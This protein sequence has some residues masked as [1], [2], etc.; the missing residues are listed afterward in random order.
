MQLQLDIMAKEQTIDAMTECTP[1]GVA[2]AGDGCA[3]DE[4]LGHN[5]AC[6]SLVAML[7]VRQFRQAT[8]QT[9]ASHMP[10]SV[11][12]RCHTH[13]CSELCTLANEWSE[14]PGKGCALARL[15]WSISGRAC[16]CKLQQFNRACA[17]APQMRHINKMVR[18]VQASM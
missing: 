7:C 14:E 8:E 1:Q 4:A 12:W 16:C 10:M 13:L 18:Q 17:E 9:K 2:A 15:A 6:I 3:F 11:I 5:V